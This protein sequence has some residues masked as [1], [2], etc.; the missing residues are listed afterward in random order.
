MSNHFLI[1]PSSLDVYYEL[2][3][4]AFFVFLVC[5]VVK[6]HSPATALKQQRSVLLLWKQ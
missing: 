6:E 4:L 5:F 1:I 3:E 2:L